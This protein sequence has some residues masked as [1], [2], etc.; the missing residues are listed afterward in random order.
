MRKRVCR[1]YIGAGISD[2]GPL[3]AH[4]RSYDARYSYYRSRGWLGVDRARFVDE[5]EAEAERAPT[6]ILRFLVNNPQKIDHGRTWI[7]R[8]N[9]P[10]AVLGFLVKRETNNESRIP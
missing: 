2:T 10:D 7:Q 3:G 8:L 1:Y 5:A 4:G 9:L 6:E